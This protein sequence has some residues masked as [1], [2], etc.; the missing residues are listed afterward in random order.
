MRLR[1]LLVL[2]VAAAISVTAPSGFAAVNHEEFEN[3]GD[4]NSDGAGWYDVR[5]SHVTCKDARAVARKYW[6][7]SAP[8][9]VR[10]NG[11]TYH[12]RDEQIEYEV[13]RVRCNG[14]GERKVRF[15]VGS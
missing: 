12:C 13:S 7:N 3:C 4:Q 9:H 2:A 14:S 5:A 8:D 6:N 15:K 1:T 10:V 11:R